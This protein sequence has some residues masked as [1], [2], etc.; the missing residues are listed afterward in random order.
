[1]IVRNQ[2]RVKKQAKNCPEQWEGQ[3]QQQQQALIAKYSSPTTTTT[4]RAT[5]IITS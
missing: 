3:Q 1:M 2:N 5:W 4:R